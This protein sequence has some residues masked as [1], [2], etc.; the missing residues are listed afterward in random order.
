MKKFGEFILFIVSY[1]TFSLLSAAL[2]QIG[3]DARVASR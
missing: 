1:T 3:P 2:S